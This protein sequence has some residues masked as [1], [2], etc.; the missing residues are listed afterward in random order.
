MQSEI[1]EQTQSQM[2][3]IHIRFPMVSCARMPLCTIFAIQFQIILLYCVFLS[4]S[5]SDFAV[6]S[7]RFL[8]TWKNPIANYTLAFIA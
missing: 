1:F 2:Y 8:F 4:Q 5:Q 3:D 6:Y 7:W